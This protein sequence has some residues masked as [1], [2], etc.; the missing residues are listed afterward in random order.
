[1][2][3][4]FALAVSA[5]FLVARVVI[6]THASVC[7]FASN[8]AMGSPFLDLCFVG[9]MVGVLFLVGNT[10]ATT[11]RLCVVVVRV[12]VVGSIELFEFLGFDLRR[13]GSDTLSRW[14]VDLA[15][16]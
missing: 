12:V 13:G 6:A 14:I 4:P 9:H 8:I 1:M 3:L 11:T 15:L 5:L 10:V 2:L 16:Q 7:L